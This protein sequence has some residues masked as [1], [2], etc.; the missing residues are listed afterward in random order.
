MTL[1]ASAQRA[2]WT[3][4]TGYLDVVTPAD[5]AAGA[6][7]TVTIPNQ[8]FVV[9]RS[10][11][12]TLTTDANAANRLLSVDYLL[13]SR[14]TAKRNLAT[15]LV[16]AS[17][18]NQVYHFDNQH[19][20]SEWNTGTPIFAPLQPLPLPNGWT[21]RVTVDSIQ[22]TDQLAS[23]VVVVDRYWQEHRSR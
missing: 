13:G 1:P 10:L 9:V 11:T 12:V 2:E 7:L 20:V 19:S 16:T 17:T 23:C 14:L 4:D 22:A 15:V 21:V 18:T 3:D 6:N 8:R 5:P